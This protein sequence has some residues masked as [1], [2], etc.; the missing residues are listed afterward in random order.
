MSNSDDLLVSDVA[1]ELGI[2]MKADSAA[3]LHEARLPLIRLC[4][5]NYTTD[6][7]VP[8]DLGVESLI[9]AAIDETDD[10]AE[11]E[12]LRRLFLGE[13]RYAPLHERG[14][15]AAAELGISYDALR[16]RNAKGNRRLD[17]L[18]S[19][20]AAAILELAPIDVMHEAGFDSATP[21]AVGEDVFSRASVFLSYSRDDDA[22]EGG[23]ISAIT[24]RLISEFR[25]Q[26]GE[27]LFIFQDKTS[28]DTGENWR[29]RIESGLDTTSFLLVF[30]TPSYL[31]SEACREELERFLEKEEA[32][33]RDDLVLP[34]Y[35]ATVRENTP[36]RLL[37]ALLSHQ[38]VDWRDLRFKTFDS[39]EVRIAIAQLA[40]AIGSAIARIALPVPTQVKTSNDESLGVVERL[41]AME[42]SLPRLVRSI[43][44]MTDEQQGI[45][46]EFSWAT[47]EIE[48]LD[49]RGG[50]S[51]ARLI[52]AR[53][54]AARLEPYAERLEELSRDMNRDLRST[55]QGVEAMSEQIPKSSEEGIDQVTEELIASVRQARDASEQAAES[56]ESLSSTYRD[57]STTVSSIAPVLRRF[58]AAVAVV[59]E[60]PNWFSRWIDMLEGA[61]A[62]RKC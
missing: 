8:D 3:S 60:C 44:A 38:Y 32:L 27:D 49:R 30:L 13:D 56:V 12:A 48:R 40:S 46:E 58:G 4:A 36:D 55:D 31:R 54:L 39:P 45:T 42:R 20:L 41:A 59:A 26:T 28:I 21:P 43:V 18:V 17:H 50:A 52:V 5:D 7:S 11:R 22:H 61:K 24:E 25:F 1:N 29:R 37:S 9:S 23:L 62:E 2:V 10:E 53:K 57:V 15:R 34:V 47:A 33:G 35:F 19:V 51:N 14:A 16:R 6:D